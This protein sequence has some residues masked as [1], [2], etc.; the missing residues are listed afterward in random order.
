MRRKFRRFGLSALLSVMLVSMTGLLSCPSEQPQAL[1]I[2]DAMAMTQQQQCSVR[3]GGGAQIIRPFGVLDLAITNRYWLFPRFKNMMPT[4]AEITG[5]G[6]SSGAPTETNVLSVYKAS[7]GIEVSAD[8]LVGD[9]E[10]PGFNLNNQAQFDL[11]EQYVS[12]RVSS[13]VAASVAPT[14][15]GAV[16]VEAVNAEFGGSVLETRMMDLLGP[17]NSNHPGFWLTLKVKLK[18]MTQDLKEV[19]SNDFWFPVQICWCCLCM[20]D[21]ISPEPPGSSQVPCFPGQDDGLPVTLWQ[22]PG[23]ANHPECCFKKCGWIP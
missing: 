14:E 2:L 7:T 23:M 19:T 12:G 1:L 4:L 3:P 9:P 6:P 8:F 16:A 11:W 5:E 13:I 15:E 18:G 22:V 17:N 10:Q 20:C 21:T